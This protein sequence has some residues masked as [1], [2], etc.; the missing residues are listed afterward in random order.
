ML[1]TAKCYVSTRYRMRFMPSSSL[2]SS[3]EDSLRLSGGC[4]VWR[5]SFVD[6][7]VTLV[8]FSQR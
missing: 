1:E 5:K 7:E 2:Y 4:L 3:W 6:E 8:W